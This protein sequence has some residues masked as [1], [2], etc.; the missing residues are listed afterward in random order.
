MP[1]ITANC[2]DSYLYTS[3]Y[4][5][6]LRLRFFVPIWPL[7]IPIYFV[8]KYLTRFITLKFQSPQIMQSMANCFS[9]FIVLEMT[10]CKSACSE[11][12]GFFPN[13][14]VFFTFS[15]QKKISPFKQM[16]KF[17]LNM[18]SNFK[19]D[20]M[21]AVCNYTLSNSGVYCLSLYNLLIKTTCCDFT[22]KRSSNTLKNRKS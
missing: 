19:D 6:L 2:D 10:L 13:Q 22:N 8:Y 18:Y 15:E 20:E 17:T 4:G 12:I 21:V 11:I 16:F 7:I 3:C 9:L 5:M 14:K 1:Q